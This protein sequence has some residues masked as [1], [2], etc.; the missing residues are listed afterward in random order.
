MTSEGPVNLFQNTAGKNMAKESAEIVK[1]TGGESPIRIENND[2]DETLPPCRE[3]ERHFF[4]RTNTFNVFDAT[5]VLISMVTFAADIATDGLAASQYFVHGEPGWGCLTLGFTLLPSIIIQ[6]FSVRW[7][8][9]DEDMT[10]W[11]WVFHCCLIGPVERYVTVFETGLEARR[12]RDP[13]DFER[14]HHQQSDVCMLRLFESFLESAPQVVLQLYIMVATNDENLFTGIAGTVSLF[15][16]CWAVV[17][18]S[19]AHR[20]VRTDKNGI[21]WPGA[22]LQT[23]W[24]IGMISSRVVAL[25]L[26]ASA[27]KAYTFLV[28]G[29]HWLA[30]VAWVYFQR[31]DFCDSWPEERL[32]NCVI[33][34]VYV[35]CFFNL[36]EGN[37]RYR[38]SIFYLIVAVENIVLLLLWHRFGMLE[39]WY[40]FLGF[41]VVFGGFIIG[42][43]AMIFYYRFF[44]P[45]GAI[46]FCFR[47]QDDKSDVCQHG[48]SNRLSTLSRHG[49]VNAEI[50]HRSRT[51]SP[52]KCPLDGKPGLH[53]QDPGS[54][55]A[56]TPCKYSPL[57]TQPG[58]L[59]WR[60]APP[61]RSKSLGCL[62]T[63]E[64]ECESNTQLSGKFKSLDHLGKTDKPSKPISSP[65]KDSPEPCTCSFQ[66]YQ[67]SG[68]A[69]DLVDRYDKSKD[70]VLA[71]SLLADES[72][73]SLYSARSCAA[74]YRTPCQACLKFESG[75]STQMKSANRIRSFS[76][77]NTPSTTRELKPA[78]YEIHPSQQVTV[79]FASGTEAPQ[80]PTRPNTETPETVSD[81]EIS[82]VSADLAQMPD[83]IDSPESAGKMS[84]YEVQKIY[85]QILDRQPAPRISKRQL[86]FDKDLDNQEVL[87]SLVSGTG[88]A[89]QNCPETVDNA[90]QLKSKSEEVCGLNTT[91]CKQLL[92]PKTKAS[93]G[94]IKHQ[95]KPLENKL[96]SPAYKHKPEE[97]ET[98]SCH[99]VSDE[100]PA[101]TEMEQ[102]KN[103]RVE[104][105]ESVCTETVL[106]CDSSTESEDYGPCTEFI[107]PGTE[108]NTVSRKVCKPHPMKQ[109]DGISLPAKSASARRSVVTKAERGK[110]VEASSSKRST[111]EAEPSSETAGK[112][113]GADIP[114]SNKLSQDV[115]GA[116]NVT[117][118]N[119][120]TRSRC[121]ETNPSP[122]GETATCQSV[123]PVKPVQIS[124]VANMSKR[125]DRLSMTRTSDNLPNAA[126]ASPAYFPHDVKPIYKY[127]GSK[128]SHLG[129]TLTTP[130]S[131]SVG[132]S[133]SAAKTQKTALPFKRAQS[134]TLIESEN[135]NHQPVSHPTPNSPHS[136]SFTSPKAK[137]GQGG[138]LS[139]GPGKENKPLT[140]LSARLALLSPS[141]NPSSPHRKPPRKSLGRIPNNLVAENVALF[142]N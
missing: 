133:I 30:M 93:P 49:D 107:I 130:E 108:T 14:L 75:R 6:V 99:D 52:Q 80:T 74:K 28:V 33:G 60:T 56:G 103:E 106:A 118:Y 44:H 12:S 116:Q 15:S 68:F 5:I 119:L 92:I 95:Q 2:L 138:V 26:F 69:T 18:Y 72:K 59:D 48:K 29:L 4:A 63:M 55:R 135:T 82:Q 35:F 132:G 19:R 122:S 50:F 124:E 53:M 89:T 91:K 110:D 76:Q 64:S 104:I 51:P 57:K 139:S 123:C 105:P 58:S 21:S 70:L 73:V 7:Y 3:C 22:I 127:G 90:E 32:F 39:D 1:E 45:R 38:I 84:A 117:H 46:S 54:D 43:T 16:L 34:T 9:A 136:K 47:A 115:Q 77:P 65:S 79:H 66:M 129:P 94:T 113:T 126:S 101:T 120:N 141:P 128:S 36:K 112:A 81:M 31:T 86:R 85:D 78:H 142:N 20:R 83:C 61:L 131:K 23:I 121:D 10:G 98:K 140:P 11:R 25:V 37:T 87:S 102:S 100:K 42:V 109:A 96:P 40:T 71:Q 27:F 67:L 134:N 125:D 62:L 114:G 137:L 41:I 17:A 88:I 24:R 8:L 97:N 13:L 111:E